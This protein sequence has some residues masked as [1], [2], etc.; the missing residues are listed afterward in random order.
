MPASWRPSGFTVLEL[1]VALAVGAA[2]L[3]LGIPGYGA[4]IAEMELRDRVAALVEA[5]SL[6][7]AEAI[8]RG[9]RVNLCPSVDATYCADDG[10]WEAGWIIFA[11]TNH[12]GERDDDETIV[13]VQDRARPGITVRGNRPVADYVSYT[14]LGQTRM[15]N[16]ALQMGTLTVCRQGRNGIAIVLANGG[17]VRVD[18]GGPPCP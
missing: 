1:L 14:G 5:M 16:G 18:R 2:L 6:A 12:D 10:R 17:R 3:L 8:K 7:R 4:W 15:V 9:V 13:R 11:D